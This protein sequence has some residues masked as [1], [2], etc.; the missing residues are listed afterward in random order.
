MMNKRQQGWIVL[1]CALIELGGSGSKQEVLTYIQDKAFW[2]QNDSNNTSLSSRREY[3]WRNE[4]AYG[5]QHM[6]DRG[7]IRNDTRDQWVIT[8]NG[9]QLFKT[10]SAMLIEEYPFEDMRFTEAFYEHL[11]REEAVSEDSSEERWLKQVTQT[12]ARETTPTPPENTPKPKG[13]YTMT[14]HRKQYR[15][16]PKIAQNALL[17]AGYKC[18]MD[19]DHSSFLCRNGQ[20]P[21]MEPHHLIPIS[22]TD[23]FDVSLDREQNIICLC[24]TCH[25]RIHYGTQED[26]RQMLSVLFRSRADKLCSILGK[27]ITEEELFPMYR[28]QNSAD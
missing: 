3:R 1:L 7:C 24:S 2:Y 19:P 15:R 11:L 27:T 18:E 22:M 8:D 28:V 26:I 9:R 17:L 6:V 4:I 16:D 13:Q 20:H 25:N 23:R 12:E 14:G 21:Y 5:R 10:L